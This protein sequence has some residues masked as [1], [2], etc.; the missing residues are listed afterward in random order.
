MGVVAKT[1]APTVGDMFVFEALEVVSLV[2]GEEVLKGFPLC[3]GLCQ[4]VHRRP[5]IS[6]YVQS[7]PRPLFLTGSPMEGDVLTS[8][9]AAAK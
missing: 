4:R 7:G 2:L 6:D 1:A 8:I 5:R 9:A 3:S